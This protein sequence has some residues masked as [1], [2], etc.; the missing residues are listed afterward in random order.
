MMSPNTDHRIDITVVGAG[1]ELCLCKMTKT[2]NHSL[3]ASMIKTIEN[4]I[5]N[6]NNNLDD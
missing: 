5:E 1:V 4:N 6:I 2:A 3:H